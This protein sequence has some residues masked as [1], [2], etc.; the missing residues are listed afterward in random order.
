MT[1]VPGVVLFGYTWLFRG[2]ETGG[3]S[4]I[5]DIAG[6]Y[7]VSEKSLRGILAD[8]KDEAKRLEALKAIL[9]ST[10]AQAKEVLNKLKQAEPQAASVRRHK[11]GKMVVGSIVLIVVGLIALASSY[12][13]PSKAADAAEPNNKPPVVLDDPGPK[14]V[15]PAPSVPGVV[16]PDVGVPAASTGETIPVAKVSL[17][18]TA[19]KFVEQNVRT[20]VKDDGWL[21]LEPPFQVSEM[22]LEFE[23]F[24]QTAAKPG[25][26]RRG[27]EEV[28]G[29]RLGT[30]KIIADPLG[31]D[32]LRFD[33]VGQ[34]ESGKMLF[35]CRVLDAKQRPIDVRVTM[36]VAS[37]KPL[38]IES[39]AV[40]SWCEVDAQKVGLDVDPK[41]LLEN[42]MSLIAVRP[43]TSRG[44]KCEIDAVRAQL[45][46]T[47]KP[48]YEGEDVITYTVQDNWKQQAQATVRVRVGPRN[49]LSMTPVQQSRTVDGV[50]RVEFKEQ[51]VPG[52][53]RTYTFFSDQWN[54]EFRVGVKMIAE[55]RVYLQPANN[56]LS[57]TFDG[58]T[59]EE[60]IEFVIT[61]IGSDKDVCEGVLVIQAAD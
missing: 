29:D 15:V 14:P 45:V 16:V 4:V 1:G 21:D 6:Q 50:R 19:A 55:E 57:F 35:V 48:G 27:K 31:G 13:V 32:A 10:E 61:H 39:E 7:R 17:K 26:N 30:L 43:E 2:S 37:E 11:S 8:F 44:G 28:R 36:L 23:R 54:E 3:E 25:L 49:F 38:P 58:T 40:R 34:L 22:V 12:F 59:L 33:A 24:G 53:P 42:A 47:P 20:I 46:Y 18:V 52:K 9:N 51:Q 56:Q 41:D 60:R 5:H